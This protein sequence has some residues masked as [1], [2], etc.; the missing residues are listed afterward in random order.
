MV[1]AHEGLGRAALNAK[2]VTLR[3]LVLVLLGFQQNAC[4]IVGIQ[5]DEF[6]CVVELNGSQLGAE[7]QERVIL[8][9]IH[10]PDSLSLTGLDY[11][12]WLASL[13]I[14]D[15]KLAAFVGADQVRATS[16][17]THTSDRSWNSKEEPH[18][19]SGFD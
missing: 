8:A 19:L 6:L 1:A 10:R 17:K 18:A 15:D 2:G 14:E 7:C 3:L 5:Q 9:Y 11:I 12:D 16:H 4:P 13:D